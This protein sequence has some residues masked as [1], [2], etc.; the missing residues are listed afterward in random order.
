MVG[1][2]GTRQLEAEFRLGNRHLRACSFYFLDL[3]FRYQS[4]KSQTLRSVLLPETPG[5]VS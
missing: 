1:V 4:S 2:G 5:T 3:G